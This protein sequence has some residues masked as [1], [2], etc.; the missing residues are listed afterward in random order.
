MRE[1]L[2]EHIKYIH[3]KTITVYSFSC[4]SR[5]LNKIKIFGDVLTT[6]YY[7]HSVTCCLTGDRECYN[8][9]DQL[10]R[11]AI[12]KHNLAKRQVSLCDSLL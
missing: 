9:D 3:I 12:N 2:P 7:L 4:K 8:Y 1:Q 10:E 5:S 6:F 11:F